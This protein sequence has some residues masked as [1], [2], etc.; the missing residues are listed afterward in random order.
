MPLASGIHLKKLSI[1]LVII[2]LVED[3]CCLL[4]LLVY[5]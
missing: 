3:V 1:I 2:H 4:W 5:P